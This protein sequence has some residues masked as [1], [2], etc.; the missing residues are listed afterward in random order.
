VKARDHDKGV[1]FG[2]EKESVGKFTQTRAMHILKNSL[3]LVRILL[4]T[5]DD[6]L[7]FFEKASPETVV[8][9]LVPILSV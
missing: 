9:G 1:N 2:S 7:N 6:S 3:E 4:Q 8:R 5:Q